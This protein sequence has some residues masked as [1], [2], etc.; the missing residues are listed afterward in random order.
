MKQLR[1]SLGFLLLPLIS[2]LSPLLALPIVA[3]AASAEEWAA[4][5]IGQAVGG[6]VAASSMAGWGTI[7]IPKAVRAGS[8]SEQIRLYSYSF[9]IRAAVFLV[10]FPIGAWVA[11]TLAGNIQPTLVVL[12]V[13]SQAIT[14]LSLS[15]FGIAQGKPK[16]IGLFEVGPKVSFTFVSAI[17]VLLGCPVWVY[18]LMLG[19]SV[20][21]GLTAYHLKVFGSLKPQAI[22]AR[23]AVD[24]LKDHRRAWFVEVIANAYSLAPIP[25]VTLVSSLVLVAQYS[26]GDRLYRYALLA[27][28]AFGNA[29]QAG[30]VSGVGAEKVR[31]FR[32]SVGLHLSLGIIGFISF[33]TLGSRVTMILFGSE[34]A[35]DEITSIWLGVCFF[36]IST[37]TPFVRNYLLPERKD[38]FVLIMTITSSLVGI[39]SMLLLGWFVGMVGVPAGL[40]LSELLTLL[41]A[42]LGY[43]YFQ[44]QKPNPQIG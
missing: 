14:G 6:F 44:R 26:S 32:S 7:G 34:V 23:Q 38:G 40:A 10:L 25:V 16:D 4:I 29:F 27:V 3:R 21:A 28:I 30:V 20:V 36:A 33:A 41:F 12:A 31:R 18:P 42:V 11:T 2:A 1:R 17:L 13:F 8:E 43:F 9:W 22:Q 5:G 35:S 37:S 39:S 19:I 24:E 15:W